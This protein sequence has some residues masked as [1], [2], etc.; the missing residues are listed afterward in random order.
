MF[1]HY[2]TEQNYVNRFYNKFI[3]SVNISEFRAP[4]F[5][6]YQAVWSYAAEGGGKKLLR[7]QRIIYIY[8]HPFF[9]FTCTR[10]D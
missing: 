2:S 7:T 6:I 1:V 4:F 8:V 10:Y 5:Y 9:E 3:N